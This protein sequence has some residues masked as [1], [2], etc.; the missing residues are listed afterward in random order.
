MNIVYLFYKVFIILKIKVALIN[1]SLSMASSE[2]KAEQNN[3][4][5]VLITAQLG[6]ARADWGQEMLGKLPRQVTLIRGSLADEMF[7]LC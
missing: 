7:S 6:V 5:M 4:L 1:C 3:G 2:A